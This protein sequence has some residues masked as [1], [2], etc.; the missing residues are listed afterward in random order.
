MR[1]FEDK[2]NLET[3]LESMTTTTPTSSLVFYANF[4][5]QDGIAPLT[6]HQ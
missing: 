2:A 3:T 5:Q 4:T 1:P 6:D